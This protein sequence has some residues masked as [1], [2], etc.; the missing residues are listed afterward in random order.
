[1]LYY[2]RVMPRI[3]K[4]AQ[5]CATTHY[6]ASCDWCKYDDGP[7]GDIPASITTRHV[8]LLIILKGLVTL[9]SCVCVYIYIKYYYF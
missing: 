9:L 8:A 3:Q 1:M 5:L 4:S 6:M 7:C 2:F